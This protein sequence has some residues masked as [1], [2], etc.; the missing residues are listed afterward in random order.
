MDKRDIGRQLLALRHERGLTLRSAAPLCGVHY[1]T[2]GQVEKG[3]INITLDTLEGIAQGLGGAV[4]VAVT[5]SREPAPLPPPPPQRR[6][7]ARRFL[8]VLPHLPED[9]V[10]LLLVQLGL[11]E[12][13]HLP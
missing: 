4:H 12:K 8:E 5:D 2:L 3:Q 1:S 11:W 7:V 6:G 13:R 9:E 10:E